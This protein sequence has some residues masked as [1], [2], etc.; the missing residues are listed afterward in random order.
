MAKLDAESD[1]L[2]RKFLF[3]LFSLHKSIFMRCAYIANRVLSMKRVHYYNRQESRSG[4]WQG[5]PAG[6]F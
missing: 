5:H 2:S 4:S 1:V 6:T 3:F